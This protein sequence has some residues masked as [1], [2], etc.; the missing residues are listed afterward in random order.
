MAHTKGILTT[1]SLQNSSCCFR[2]NNSKACSGLRTTGVV[3]LSAITTIA[4]VGGVFLILAQ[5]G[6][7][8]GGL[9]AYAHLV[10]AQWL[11]VG[12][13]LA[14]GAG[15]LDMVIIFGM[16][17]RHAHKQYSD[18]DL[19]QL[20]ISQRIKDEY[21]V[22]KLEVGHFW[23]VDQPVERPT[24]KTEGSP[25]VYALV[26]KLGNNTAYTKGFRSSDDREA[27]IRKNGLEEKDGEKAFEE[28]LF[29]PSAYIAKVFKEGE[30]A[31]SAVVANMKKDLRNGFYLTEYLHFPDRDAQV[32]ILVVKNPDERAPRILYCKENKVDQVLQKNF[33]N[34]LSQDDVAE[35]V[36]FPKF[37]A[38]ILDPLENQ[39]FWPFT[40]T[41]KEQKLFVYHYQQDGVAKTDFARTDSLEAFTKR[42]FVNA[43]EAYAK[44]CYSEEELQKL[45]GEAKLS[46]YRTE[47]IEENGYRIFDKECESDQMV[48]V[49]H[50][51]YGLGTKVFFFRS[52]EAREK[53]I[54]AKLGRLVD[55]DLLEEM[56]FDDDDGAQ[57]IFTK[58]VL[59]KLLTD[60]NFFLPCKLVVKGVPVV[61][62]VS[63]DAEG[64]FYTRVLSE[65]EF[66]ED[67]AEHTACG[68]VDVKE[69]FVSE[70]T[71]DNA[72]VH[73]ELTEEAAEKFN[74]RPSIVSGQYYS[75]SY[76]TKDGNTIYILVFKEFSSEEIQELCFTTPDA[77]EKCTLY[78]Q[79]FLEGKLI[80]RKTLQGEVRKAISTHLLAQVFT[81]VKMCTTFTY[82]KGNQ[83]V[84]VLLYCGYKDPKQTEQG[85]TLYMKS[86]LKKSECAEEIEKQTF[87]SYST[88]TPLTETLAKSVL[89]QKD[90]KEIDELEVPDHVYRTEMFARTDIKGKNLFLLALKG[91]TQTEKLFFTTEEARGLYIVMNDL[92]R[93]HVSLSE[94][95]KRRKSDMDTEYMQ[96]LLVDH[97][98]FAT[99]DYRINGIPFYI[100]AKIGAKDVVYRSFA[101][102]S[103][104]NTATI[105]LNKVSLK[106]IPGS[107]VREAVKAE[108]YGKVYEREVLFR[109]RKREE[110][111]VMDLALQE[112]GNPIYTLIYSTQIKGKWRVVTRHFEKLDDRTE[113]I[114]KLGLSVN[115][116]TQIATIPRDFGLEALITGHN[117][118]ATSYMTPNDKHYDIVWLR[119]DDGLLTYKLYAKG[120]YTKDMAHLRDDTQR[121]FTFNFVN[122]T[123]RAEH[124]IE[125]KNLTEMLQ[126]NTQF[127]IENLLVNKSD[128]FVEEVPTVFYLEDGVIQKRAFVKRKDAPAEE[129]MN[130]AVQFCTDH[131][132]SE[133]IAKV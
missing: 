75:D 92:F 11:Y 43:R 45:L 110:Y 34:A 28:R 65:E 130:Q 76:Q 66:S 42:G 113:A 98:Q 95:E 60:E 24:E 102:E 15:G 70:N 14:A 81:E 44:V 54:S 18:Q 33:P 73:T 53:Y 133:N 96:E 69:R 52:E 32:C 122:F 17:R 2:M 63:R 88:N 86:F 55:L 21:I 105:D 85:V 30:P 71:T 58:E 126:T 103:E 48:Y 104:R 27:F 59:N 111:S 84:Y 109:N 22:E 108:E 4:L 37:A 7:N 40:I 5:Q 67:L 100:A 106:T 101:S 107:T 20:G 89:S 123:E 3:I 64:E 131:G 38:V 128:F 57:P 1:D 115:Y 74:K 132:L 8:L 119:A 91:P 78:I 29:Y 31:L 61:A 41:F 121:I 12:V 62:L 112:S 77:Q 13:G 79:A 118:F 116:D 39:E 80:C 82:S 125:Q 83:Q 9:N 68:W 6:V 19:V 114:G 120:T 47:K 99:Y 10:E 56:I 127:L 46:K 129:A 117:Y 49:L 25:A 124:V 16:I 36:T 26:V 93:T 87:R 35:V 90:S 97:K 50:F 94:L 72:A 51:N 23:K